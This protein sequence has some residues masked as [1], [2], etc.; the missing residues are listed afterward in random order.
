MAL[1][2][3]GAELSW[4]SEVVTEQSGLLESLDSPWLLPFSPNLYNIW[5]KKKE[6]AII[7]W[8]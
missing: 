7:I 5:K 6:Y 1:G 4:I 2:D 3:S 8:Q